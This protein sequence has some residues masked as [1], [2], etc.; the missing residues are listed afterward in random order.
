ME[1]DHFN[2]NKKSDPIQQYANLFLATRHCNGA[3]RDRWPTNKERQLGARFLNCCQES[4]YGVH[5]FE[6]PDTHEVV[7]VTPEGR[8]HVRNCDL[9]APHLIEERT[10]RAKLRQLLDARQI[11]IK[12]GWSLPEH[13]EALRAVV[14]KMIPVIPYLIG[15]DLEKHRA[16]KRALAQ[17]PT[18]VG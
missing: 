11:T 7:G 17:L 4:D 9:N 10:E 2:P 18:D 13:V 1:I 14:E 5:I 8:Y 15:D 3:K 12:Q 6:D 16:L